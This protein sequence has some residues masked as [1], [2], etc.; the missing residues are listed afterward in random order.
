MRNSIFQLM[1]HTLDPLSDGR[2]KEKASILHKIAR[3][4]GQD[5]ANGVV[6]KNLPNSTNVEVEVT[7]PMNGSAGAEVMSQ[8]D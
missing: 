6:D 5:E 8:H 2:F 3:K 4:K 1:I 7:P